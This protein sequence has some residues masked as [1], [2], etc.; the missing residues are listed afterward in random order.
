MKLKH[1]YALSMVGL[2]SLMFGAGWIVLSRVVD[3]P[4][5]SMVSAVGLILA[6]LGLAILIK[7]L[8]TIEKIDLIIDEEEE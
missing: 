3:Y 1:Q 6:G 5:I 2:A 8:S 7:T 4:P